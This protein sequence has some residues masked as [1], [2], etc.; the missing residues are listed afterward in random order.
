MISDNW[1]KL[2][3]TCQLSVNGEKFS[4]DEVE[5]TLYCD[6]FAETI[7]DYGYCMDQILNPDETGLNYQMFSSKVIGVKADREIPGAKKIQGMCDFPDMYKC[8]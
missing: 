2:Y 8:I 7:F 3:G 1:V 6:E 4:V 5:A